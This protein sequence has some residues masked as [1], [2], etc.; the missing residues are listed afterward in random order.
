MAV[1]AISLSAINRNT[2][3]NPVRICTFARLRALAWSHDV[4]YA[5]RGYTLLSA[6]VGTHA[7]IEWSHV[8]QFRPAAW[9]TI[10]S[11][12]RL[13]SRLF[14]DGFHALVALSSGH[15]VGAVPHAIVTLAP[16][17]KEFRV[18]HKLLR[19]TRPL[20]LAVTPGDDIFWGEYFD[21]PQRNEVHI[22]G[23]TDR[24]AHWDVA[25]TFPNGTI[26][27]VH[28]IVY[29]EWGKCF[30]VLTGDHGS[31]CR[32]LRASCDF[33]NVDVVLS[34][35]QQVRS[36]ALVPTRDAL[37]FSSDTPLE[38]NHVY[39][40]DRRGIDRRGNLVRLA[41]LNRSSIYGCRVG[42][43]VFF[44]T[45]VEPSP[46]NS[47][48]DVCLYGSPDGLD[49]HR[50]GQRKKDLWPMGLFQYGNAFLPDGKNA[51]NLLAVTTIAVE[52]ADL[53]TSIWQI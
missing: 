37:Y 32:I 40:L 49:W 47:D 7:A 48:R 42:N 43:A 18:S 28:N 24:G 51:T 22:Y 17:D 27:H 21:N 26:R 29:D 15:L 9:R 13:A 8:G 53:E 44:S 1:P 35:Y 12:S 52:G 6:R 23:S 38:T 2:E 10:T 36:A 16:G 5:S 25:Y 41:A 4:L 20:H 11:S 39:R 14:R 3:L 30:W 33:K 19:G 50:F 34:G 46:I 45:M 31:E